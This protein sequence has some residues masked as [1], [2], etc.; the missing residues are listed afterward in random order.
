MLPGRRVPARPIALALLASAVTAGA[1][2]AQVPAAPPATLTIDAAVQEAIDRNLTVVAERYSVSVAQA[3]IVT[4]RLRPNPVVTF[5]AMLPDAT[6]FA[7]DISPREQVLRTDLVIERGAKRERRVDVA[8]QARSVAE[9][10]LLN[11]IR[12]IV[13]DVESACVDVVLAEQNLAL[14][15]E[16]LDAF[17]TLVQL[18]TERVRTGDLAQVELARSRLAALQ[19]QNDV[20]QQQAKLAVAQNHLKMLL[21]RAGPGAIDITGELRRDPQPI[22]LAAVRRLALTARPDLEA[23]RRDQARSAADLRL[24]IAQGRV[25]YTISGEVHHQHQATPAVDN[26]EFVYDAYVSVPLPIFNRNQGEV[27][28]AREEERQALARITALGGQIVSEV[29]QAYETYA[30]ARDVVATIESQ[31]L[32]PARDVRTTTE[33]SYRR[34]EASFIEFL[35]A[36]RAF[37]DTMQSYNAARAE[38]ARSLYSLEASAG[39]RGVNP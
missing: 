32:A 31:M 5:N 20:R 26:S 21:G 4:A 29:E 7:Q 30:A 17:N 6:V 3:R 34:G 10:Q 38:Y 36:S 9:L 35:D 24:Q 12:T 2:A 33:Y 15:H 16:S 22:D 8:E 19:F 28:R 11:T 13:L 1:V 37:N 27:A 18:N 14:A 25:D 23:L 39:G